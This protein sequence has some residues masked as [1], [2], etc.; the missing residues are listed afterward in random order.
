MDLE[1]GS[2]P[3]PQDPKPASDLWLVWMLLGIVPI[4]IGLLIGPI[5]IFNSI[6]ARINPYLCATQW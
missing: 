2:V 3:R 6:Q 5:N 4:P 1:K